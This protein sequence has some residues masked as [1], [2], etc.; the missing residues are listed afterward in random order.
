MLFNGLAHGPSQS[1]AIVQVVNGAHGRYRDG[2]EVL[3]FVHVAHGH[4]GA[5]LGVE[6]GGVV[7]QCFHAMF[8]AH[9]G[10]QLAQFGVAGALERHVGNEVRQ[11]VAGVAAFEVRRAVDVVVGVDQPVGVEHHDGVHAQFAAAAADFLVAVDGVLARALARAVQ[12]AEV[13]AGNVGDFGDEC[14]FAHG[15]SLGVFVGG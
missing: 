2:F 13:H 6:R 7:G 11:L 1:G 12:L 4:Q 9:L 10:Q 14:E 3:V 8:H 15:V 5:V